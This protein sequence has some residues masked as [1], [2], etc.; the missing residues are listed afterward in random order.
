MIKIIDG[1]TAEVDGRQVKFDYFNEGDRVRATEGFKQG[2]VASDTAGEIVGKRR[3][4]FG[5]VVYS[6]RWADG[7]TTEVANA[8]LLLRRA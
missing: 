2:G 8:H 5:V 1:A 4:P 3:L 6:V 7:R